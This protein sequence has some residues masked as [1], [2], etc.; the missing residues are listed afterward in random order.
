MDLDISQYLDIFGEE[1]KEHLQD[2]NDILLV[3]EKDTENDELLN[4]LFRISHTLKGMS[5]TMG[6]TNMAN[7]THCMEDVL[8]AVRSDEVAINTKIVDMLF[9]CLDALEFSVDFVSENGEEDED[10]H[11]E[12]IKRLKGLLNKEEELV[13]EKKKAEEIKK[14]DE[15]IINAVNEAE[16]QGLN[17][18]DI[19]IKLSPDCMLKSAR[20]FIIFNTVE[21]FSEIIHSNPDVEDIEDEKFDL[22][23]SLV[24]ITEYP[25]DK[26]KEELIKVSEIDRI[27]INFVEI[28]LNEK[29]RP[30]KNVKKD[31]IP[32]N[33]DKKK[34]FK[35]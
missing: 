16:I 22:D 3:L 2:M 15:Y 20:A 26:V 19:Y 10:D 24:I 35:D 23:F 30:K 34:C 28:G 4:E 27:D 17:S 25:E 6:F 12:L 32:K 14:Y 31:S 7:L 18:Y 11:L 29:Q 13:D 5:A 8:Q 21:S 33:M 1:S 9:Q